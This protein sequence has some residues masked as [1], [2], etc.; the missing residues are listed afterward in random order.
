MDGA[1]PSTEKKNLLKSQSP[2][3]EGTHAFD[4]E[5][6]HIHAEKELPPPPHSNSRWATVFLLLNTMI[7]SGILNQP[8]VFK[9]A[10]ILGA[11]V[12]FVISAVFIWTGIV[13]L[14]ECGEEHKKLDYSELAKY[15]FPSWGELIIDAMIV[16]NNFGAL[17]SYITV[18]GGTSAMLLRDWGCEDEACGFY[19]MS[20]ILMIFLVLPFCLLRYYGHLTYVSYLSIFAI[21]CV[22]FL[23]IFGGPF[24]AKE[25]RI[26][27]FHGAG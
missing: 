13:A 23:V 5:V 25:G 21:V 10:G 20:I 22:L 26:V 16:L 19:S 1:K 24:Y 17:L 3:A 12:M 15:A 18:V 9:E 27:V 11:T 2:H 6:L 14:I 8:E 4:I 7:G